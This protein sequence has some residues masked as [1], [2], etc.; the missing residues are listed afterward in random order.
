MKLSTNIMSFDL[1]HIADLKFGLYTKPLESGNAV[2]LQAK[3][4]DDQGNQT[5]VVDSYLQIDQKNESHLLGDGDILLVG[6][7]FRNFAWTYRQEYGPALAS[8]IFFVIT[9]N[10]DFVIPEFLTIF[11]NLPSTQ[12]YF[13][14]LG[15]GSSIPSIRKS[16]LEAL[17]IML[18]SIEQQ[19]RAITIKQLH[20]KDMH[21]SQKILTEKQRIYQAV[22]KNLIDQN[23]EQTHNT[24]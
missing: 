9:P 14:T 19:E 12:A 5:E 21:L 3:H 18:P 15:A 8:S 1:A 23:H 4:F 22:I 24:E 10:T 17:K 20:Y 11:F 16:E 7:G 6:K 2:Y 13:Q